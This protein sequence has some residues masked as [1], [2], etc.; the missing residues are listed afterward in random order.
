MDSELVFELFK[1]FLS[2]GMDVLKIPENNRLV[3]KPGVLFVSNKTEPI[4]LDETKGI[5]YIFPLF[6]ELISCGKE[7]PTPIRFLAYG[8]ANKWKRF[9]EKGFLIEDNEKDIITS[10]AIAILKGLQLFNQNKLHSIF[11]QIRKKVRELSG[12]EIELKKAT[13]DKTAR[14]ISVLVHDSA[15]VRY[16]NE[17]TYLMSKERTVIKPLKRF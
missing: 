16:M 14:N 13:N 17:V 10:Y 3:C 12:L 15:F 9:L 5:L 11:S 8:Y 2:E 4:F 1:E 6:F 7:T